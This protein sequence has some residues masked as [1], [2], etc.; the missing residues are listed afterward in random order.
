VDGFRLDVA[1]SIPL[2]FWEEARQDLEIIRPGIVLVAEGQKPENLIYAFDANYGWPVCNIVRKYMRES[3]EGK[4]D[5][6]AA[7][8][9]KAHE[10]WTSSCP[11]GGLSWNFM[12]NHD[13][14]TDSF[15]KRHEKVWGYERC[16]LAMAY[17]FAIDGVPFI[18][19][20]EEVCYDMRVSLFGHKD[21][22]IDWKACLDTPHAIE[23]K[24]NIQTWVAMRKAYSALTDGETVWIDNDQPASVLSFLRH[25]GV[26]PDVY[27]I[28]NFSDKKVKVKL[29]DGTKYKLEP[30]DFFFGAKK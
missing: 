2:D 24:A 27:F 21:C 16:T 8:L 11:K 13:I 14:S 10:K 30:W 12:E 9:R 29:S 5:I 20:G 19:T 15:E 1:D 7:S 23:R 22:W 18:F 6:D 4:E 26:S 17:C 25:D 28:G 3:T